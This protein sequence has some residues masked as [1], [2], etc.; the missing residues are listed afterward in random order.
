MI[1]V[2]SFVN[3]FM[4]QD[5]GL[6]RNQIAIITESEDLVFDS[7]LPEEDP[8]GIIDLPILE[9]PVKKSYTF[10]NGTLIIVI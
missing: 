5:T 1:T 8:C 4:D 10:D 6:F 9:S 2:D 3:L 7:S